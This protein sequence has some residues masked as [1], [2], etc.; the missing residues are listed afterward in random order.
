[1]SASLLRIGIIAF[2]MVAAVPAGAKTDLADGMEKRSG[3][4]PAEQKVMTVSAGE[5]MY[6]TFNYTIR[7]IV[8]PS[9]DIAIKAAGFHFTVKAGDAMIYNVRRG[10][11]EACSDEP[12][13]PGLLSGG[14]FHCFT[15]VDSDGDFDQADVETRNPN[16]NLPSSVKYTWD[17]VVITDLPFH[18]TVLNYV[19]K[20]GPSLRLSYREFTDG[21]ARPAFTEEL[22]IPL[23]EDYPQAMVVK[24]VR[25]VIH[26]I[27]GEGVTYAVTP[28]PAP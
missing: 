20:D 7:K 23:S 24:G 27:D 22:A 11:I 18:K 21:M 25:F 28:K 1:M 3:S 9:Q 17:E 14:T 2:C 10:G 19:G 8:R 4:K 15:D 6:E 13:R 5:P 12:P 16:R 26:K